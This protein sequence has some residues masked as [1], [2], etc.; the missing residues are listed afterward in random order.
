MPLEGGRNWVVMGNKLFCDLK[1]IW[2]DL[3]KVRNAVDPILQL[4]KTPPKNNRDYLVIYF[5]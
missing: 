5:Y 3:E 4:K 1:K 2:E